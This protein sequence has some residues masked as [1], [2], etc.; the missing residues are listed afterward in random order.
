MFRVPVQHYKHST[1][2]CVGTS[3][4]PYCTRLLGLLV[5][6]LYTVYFLIPGSTSPQTVLHNE[7]LRTLFPFQI[8]LFLRQ[9]Q[10]NILGKLGSTALISTLQ[11][12][13][14]YIN[15]L[16]TFFFF[17]IQFLCCELVFAMST[18]ISAT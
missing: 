14:T 10:C 4:F 12:C 2:Q 16:I 7:T 13:C 11:G 8:S 18:S 6:S 9:A 1:S 17:H 15:V 5:N 3:D